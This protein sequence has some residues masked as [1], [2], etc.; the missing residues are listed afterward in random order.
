MSIAIAIDIQI[1]LFHARRGNPLPFVT[2][3]IIRG[4][5]PQPDDQ[6]YRHLPDGRLRA[7]Q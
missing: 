6:Y 1:T 7:S 2:G 4:G 3:C 5:L